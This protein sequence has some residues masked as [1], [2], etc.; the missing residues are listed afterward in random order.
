M[1]AKPAEPPLAFIDLAAQQRRIRPQIDAAIARVLDHGKYI[2]GPE[3][4]ELE[5]QL[6]AFSGAKH[7]ISCSSGTDALLMALMARDIGPGDAVLCPAFTFTATPEVIALLGAT[8]IFIDVEEASFNLDPE[9]LDEGVAAARAAGLQ[10]KAIIAVDLFGLPADYDAIEAFAEAQGM[11]V[12]ADAAQ[13][14]GGSYKERK[15]GQLGLMTATSFFP[16]K[17]LGCYGDGGAIF[18]DDDTL[19]AALESIRVHGKGTGKYDNVRIGVNGRLD[20]MQAAILIEKLKIFAIEIEARDRV[21]ARYNEAF[22]AHNEI[23]TPEVP[24]GL[25]SAWA[26][27]TLRLP[28]ERRDAIAARLKERG[29]PTAIY[30]PKPLHE[31]TA[32]KGFPVAGD[33]LPVSERLSREV[34][35]LPMHPYLDAAAQERVI[36][37]VLEA[38]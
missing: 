31:Q 4:G 34:L 12:L 30:Y 17:P 26:Q 2:M 13:G 27:Y 10:P 22:R 25:S 5:R 1:D 8:P 6:T 18:T 36:A 14:Y 33:G 24:E 38:L 32:Y 20:T 21:A 28:A 7:C 29:I 3:V 15:V 11:W 37:A 16:A 9:K 35:S 19:A 23:A